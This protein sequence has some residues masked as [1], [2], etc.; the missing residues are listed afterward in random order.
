LNDLNLK[1]DISKAISEL[2]KEK[3]VEEEGLVDEE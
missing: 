3:V 1:K 2:E